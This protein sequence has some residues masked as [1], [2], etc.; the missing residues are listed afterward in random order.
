M[1]N[2][3]FN[4]KSPESS[5]YAQS[6]VE[7][8]LYAP[9]QEILDNGYVSAA[10][11]KV[12]NSM[13]SA[14]AKRAIVKERM[15]QK[16]LNM[17]GFEE[18]EV[19][20]TDKDSG[21]IL[22]R[23]ESGNIVSR[24]PI[25][26]Q[27]YGHYDGVD[28]LEN[29]KK[30]AY[31]QAN[32]PKFVSMLTGKPEHELT[33]YDYANVK[34]YET[35]EAYNAMTFTGKGMYQ[36]A[37]YN[38]SIDYTADQTPKSAKVMVRLS[39]DDRYGRRLAEVVNLT[40][41]RDIGFEFANDPYT[42]ASFDLYKSIDTKA[43]RAGVEA[44]YK[45]YDVQSIS[46]TIADKYDTDNRFLEDLDMVQASFYRMWAR[47]AQYGPKAIMDT[48]YW[49]KVADESTGQEIADSWAG[50]KTSTRR[51]IANEMTKGLDQW[52]KGNYVDSII[53]IGSQFDRLFAESAAQTLTGA[54]VGAATLGVGL[55]A[56]AG[57][58]TAST[59]AMLS[60]ATTAAVPAGAVNFLREFRQGHF[61]RHRQHAGTVCRGIIRYTAVGEYALISTQRKIE[62]MFADI[63]HGIEVGHNILFPL[64]Q[65]CGDH[66]TAQ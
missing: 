10:H 47:A 18:Q 45:R 44:K 35:A 60:G 59:I 57:T 14:D 50:V 23:D 61:A 63:T 26:L 6:I 56:G 54:A 46:K 53:T 38:P 12:V 58:A 31:K 34:A 42:N 24:T 51:A 21:F 20:M 33:E 32:Q 40:N 65:K 52:K 3:T 11:K 30:S 17:D 7:N 16:T 48:D 13:F 55:A 8:A 2:S 15:L 19:E 28:E 66:R 1:I 4:L 5:Q 36:S 62:L 25:R 9:E 29:V 49:A 41:G 22:Q 37:R 27:A 39:G 64:V 43:N